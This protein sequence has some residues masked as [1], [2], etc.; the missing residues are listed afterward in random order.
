M[1][2]SALPPNFRDVGEASG[3]RLGTLPNHPGQK[4]KVP[5]GF[6]KHKI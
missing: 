2:N 3:L 5:Q 6:T 4:R 1:N